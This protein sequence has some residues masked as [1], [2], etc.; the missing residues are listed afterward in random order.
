[1]NNHLPPDI[2]GGGGAKYD[3]RICLTIQSVCDVL[4]TS[5]IQLFCDCVNF[6]IVTYI[7]V[8]EVGFPTV[9]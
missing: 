9:L 8:V 3:F 5:E 2:N 4:N 6:Y 1:M 7:Q